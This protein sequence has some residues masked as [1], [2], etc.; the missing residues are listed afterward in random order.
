MIMLSATVLCYSCNNNEVTPTSTC[1]IDYPDSSTVHPKGA[2]FQNIIDK[3]TKAGL[4]GISLL[5]RD[6]NGT[7]IGA[8]G[9]S[10]IEKNTAFEPCHVSKTASLTKIFMASLAYKLQEEGVIDLDD[11]VSK[12][13]SAELTKD[14]ANASDATLRQLLGHRTGIFDIISSNEFYLAV[15]NHPQKKWKAEELLKF[16]EGKDAEFKPGDSASY[17]NTNTLLLS[18]VIDQATGK[19][20]GQLLRE[21]IINPLG[22][23]HTYYFWYD[24]LPKDII[25]RGYYDLYN[26]NTLVDLSEWNTGTGCGYNGIYST[27]NDLKIFIEALFRTKTL[28]SQQSLDEMLVFFPFPESRKLLGYGAFKDFIDFPGNNYGYG[29][30]GRDL[31]YSADVFY[32]PERDITFALLVN[33]GT[34]A[35]TKLQKTFLQFRDE[36]VTEIIK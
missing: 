36:L 2:A 8:S 13:L 27:T 19:P 26:N 11:K 10:D 9:K 23:N 24:K 22:L 30:R 29:H 31:A 32:L 1:L 4:P 20:H 14:V 7:W 33:Y 21:K 35:E 6:G 18:M 5:V 16:A 15:L 25:A 34:D 17:S 3:Y 12:Y 28:L